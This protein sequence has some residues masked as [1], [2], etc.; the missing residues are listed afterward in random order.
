[1]ENMEHP[2]PRRILGA[3]SLKEILSLST[4]DA[5]QSPIGFTRTIAVTGNMKLKMVLI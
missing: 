2:Y 4:Y 3:Q 1:M 5:V